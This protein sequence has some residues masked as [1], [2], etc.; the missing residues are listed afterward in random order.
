MPQP[1]GFLPNPHTTP[2]MRVRT[3]RFTD[4]AGPKPVAELGEIRVED[5]H[6]D[7][8]DG[9]LSRRLAYL[10]DHPVNDGRNAQWACM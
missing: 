4:S 5:G 3:G 9:S 10:L 8:I 2:R 1:G 7:S 6:H